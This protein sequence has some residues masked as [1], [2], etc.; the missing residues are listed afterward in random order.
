[1]NFLNLTDT[2][3]PLEAVREKLGH[4]CATPWN[5]LKQ[6]HPKVKLKYLSEYC[7]S[8]TYILTLLTEVYNFTSEN[9]PNIKFIREIKGSDAG[10]TLGYMLNLTNMIPAE[11]PDSPPL[12]HAGYVSIVTVIAILLL[13]L[14]ILSLR[15]LWP[16]CSKRPQIV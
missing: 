12:P 15:P 14:F 11:A 6:Q 1:M 3:I 9:Y 13:V 4:Y 10:W 7:F 5:Q 2:S 8:G 16:R